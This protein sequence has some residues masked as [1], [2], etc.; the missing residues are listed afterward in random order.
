MHLPLFQAMHVDRRRLSS[1]DEIAELFASHGVSE[2]KFSEAFNAFGVGSQ[3]NQANARARSARITGTP[4]MMVNGKYR[5]STRKA[6]SQANMLKIAD[7]LIEKERSA[8]A[9]AAAP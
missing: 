6:G 4:E 7:Y 5:I 9:T 2:D 3:V 1:E 8:S